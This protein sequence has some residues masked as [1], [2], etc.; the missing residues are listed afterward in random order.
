M[1]LCCGE[2][3]IDMLP[4]TAADGSAC[5][6][7]CP[8]G[9][10]FNTAIALGR[11]GVPCGLAAGLS[12]DM[13]G[14]TLQEALEASHV[15]TA[16]C[17]ISARPSTLTFVTLEHGEARYAFY[18]ENT[19]GRMLTPQ[20]LPQPG[21]EA[22]VLFF[23][24]ISLACEPAAEAFEALALQ[25][26]AERLVMLDPNIRPAFITGETRYRRRLDRMLT[27]SDIVKLSEDDLGWLLPGAEPATEKLARIQ[28]MGPPVVLLTRGSKGAAALLPGGDIVQVPARP[29]P[30]AASGAGDTV[31]AGDSFNAGF[32]A[33]LAPD[34]QACKQAARS[35]APEAA[36]A[37][38][39]HGAAVA[40][41]T[42]SRTGA[43]PPWQHEL[44]L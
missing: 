12:S 19:A 23:G 20:E 8:G 38:L 7:P 29:A 15:S 43:N 21:P 4:A 16:G 9:A 44:D 3:L 40:A 32:L 10:V 13:F 28:A 37:A 33:A 30:A 2:A 34:G 25:S 36:E 5:F 24:G 27:V 1:I 22:A 41:V 17:V 6:T 26:H 14:Q 18:D 31:G 39:R 42:V 35:L 11:L